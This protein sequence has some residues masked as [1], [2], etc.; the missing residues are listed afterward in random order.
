MIE[1]SPFNTGLRGA[2]P[3]QA[4]D[5][6]RETEITCELAALE[7]VTE[8]VFQRHE[9]LRK[10]IAP[11]C[12]PLPPEPTPK[13]CKTSPAPL[14]GLGQRL[15]SVTCKLAQLMTEQE[16]LANLIEL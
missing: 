11:V 12:R 3:T 9:I 13:D 16:Q 10:R 15:R 14:T 1:T 2:A 7:Q 5:A 4:G 6:Q 8:I